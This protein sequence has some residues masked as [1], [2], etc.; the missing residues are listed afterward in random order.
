MSCG[1]ST[2]GER[3]GACRHANVLLVRLMAGRFRHQ[4]ILHILK[5]RAQTPSPMQ[6]TEPAMKSQNRSLSANVG[7]SFGACS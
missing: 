4:P 6:S 5:N 7:I 3:S 1:R 2:A